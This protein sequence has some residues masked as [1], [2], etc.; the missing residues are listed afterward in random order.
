[1]ASIF[2]SY[3]R[4][5]AA[6]AERIAKALE[7]NGHS[8]WWDRH[9]HAGSRFSAEIGRA[10]KTADIVVVLWSRSSVDSAWVHDEAAAGRD[11]GRLL[12]VLIDN[13]ELPLGFRQ[14]HALDLR[15]RRLNPRLLKKLSDAVA[16]NKLEPDVGI[17]RPPRSRST[18][19]RLSWKIGAVAVAAAL[20]LGAWLVFMRGTG[21][22]QNTVAIVAEGGDPARSEELAR[23][24]A[25]DLGRYR[26]GPMGS[27]RILRQRGNSSTKAKYSFE[28][29]VTGAGSELRADI[30][31]SSRDKRQLLWS[32]A[33]EGS[34][35]RLVDL[36]QQ[37]AAK[38]GG[39]LSCAIDAELH[40][41]KPGPD[42][43]ALYLN[44][45]GQLSDINSDAPGEDVLSIFRQLTTKAP[46]FAPAWATL[47]LIELQSWPG[48]PE[49]QMQ[50]VTRSAREH[51]RKAKQL[52]PASP[53]IFA[54]E[55]ALPESFFNPEQ[56]LA[57]L[58]RG[59][60]LHPD[61]ARLRS[62]RAESLIRVGRVNEA[63]SETRKATELDPLS[64]AFRGGYIYALATAGRTQA[65]FDELKKADATWPGS[66]VLRQVHY[67]LNLRYGDPKLGLRILKQRG[68]PDARPVPSDVAW[69]AFLEARIDPSPAKIETALSAFR[70]RAR[71]N[72]G[73][74]AYIQA[75]GTFERVDEAYAALRSQEAL[76]N[77]S[78]GQE[79]LFRPFMRSFRADPRFMNV[80]YRLGLLSYWKKSGR[81]PD[82]CRDPQLPYECSKEAA[83]Y[84]REAPA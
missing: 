51:L 41:S 54:A 61:N 2:L 23:S 42:A 65:A 39:V 59:I 28:V 63:V 53:M 7:G 80:A 66:T 21:T 16:E 46:N 20:L 44:G 27:L 29:G 73:Q 58:D 35:I 43:L 82:F 47:A 30:A 10:L 72:P 5:D 52:D 84:P 55:S 48:T 45:C 57:I 32:A 81:W 12:P 70:D 67:L 9:L 33:V 25:L 18:Q 74:P 34:A 69:Q 4:E 56:G 49:P 64:P 19:L 31:M 62:L 50:A 13:V 6:K 60:T 24:V 78:G 36:R 40:R 38:I 11:S 79:S 17:A 76:E 1:M 15:A 71:R 68:A 75:L 77:F 83:K 22:Q 3:A 37:V 26:A 14:Y 8:V